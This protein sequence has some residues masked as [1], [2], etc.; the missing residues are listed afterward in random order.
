MD[1]KRGRRGNDFSLLRAG[2]RQAHVGFFAVPSREELSLENGR[3]P[4]GD[5]RARS[6]KEN[7]LEIVT[8]P[9][10]VNHDQEPN[11]F[12]LAEPKKRAEE[13]RTAPFSGVTKPLNSRVQSKTTPSPSGNKQRFLRSRGIF[14]RP[15]RQGVYPFVAVKV[16]KFKENK[17]GVGESGSS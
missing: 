10:S 8:K 7:K 5:S 16:K 11:V 15:D 3:E 17:G 9:E 14:Q 13:T 4:K 2:G 1:L 6:N 12:V